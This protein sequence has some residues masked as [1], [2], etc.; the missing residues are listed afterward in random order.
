VLRPQ[1]NLGTRP[2]AK[3]EDTI[4]LKFTIFALVLTFSGA[5]L[6]CPVGYVPC[7]ESYQLCCPGY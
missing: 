5:A 2:H 3:Q 7:G 1:R 6:A 4:M